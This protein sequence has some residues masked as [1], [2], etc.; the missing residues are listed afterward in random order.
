M[1]YLIP[2]KIKSVYA[3][4]KNVINEGV[5]DYFK[6]MCSFDSGITYTV[7][8]GTYLLRPLPRWYV[9]GN[10]GTLVIKSFFD[11]AEIIR[12]GEHVNELPA[13]IDE[14]KAGPTRSMAKRAAEALQTEVVSTGTPK[15]SM[16]YENYLA[17]LNG[18]A[19]LSIK[20]EQVMRVLKL[21]DA[22]RLSARINQSVPFDEL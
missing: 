22:I 2:G 15:W 16:Y 4:M 12:S 21:M 10:K 19:E 7:E 14:S 17:A 1:L 20:N 13:S 9:A 3:D 8:I 6:V 18:E 5:D 11:D